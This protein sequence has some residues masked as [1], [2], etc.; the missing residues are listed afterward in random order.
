MLDEFSEGVQRVERIPRAERV[1][2]QR[3]ERGFGLAVCRR[4]G[5][6]RRREQV[7]LLAAQRLLENLQVDIAKAREVL[8]WSPPVTIEEGLRRALQPLRGA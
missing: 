4:V 2:V 6:G 5:G 8:A 7:Y 3:G 1:R